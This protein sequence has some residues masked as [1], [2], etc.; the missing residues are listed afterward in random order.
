MQID[1]GKKMKRTL[2]FAALFLYHVP[3]LAQTS[4][5]GPYPDWI[6]HLKMGANGW[7]RASSEALDQATAAHS[8]CLE[9]E[10]AVKESEEAR[11]RI[12]KRSAELAVDVLEQGVKAAVAN[13]VKRGVNDRLGFEAFPTTSVS[14]VVQEA[15]KAAPGE[16]IVAGVGPEPED[17]VLKLADS[18][19]QQGY[20][21]ANS[22]SRVVGEP[23][24]RSAIRAGDRANALL[25]DSLYSFSSPTPTWA[26]T[27]VTNNLM[28][29]SNRSETFDA[30]IGQL[31][32]QAADDARA[33]EQR[34]AEAARIRE[35]RAAQEI[36]DGN[37]EHEAYMRRTAESKEAER[38]RSSVRVADI[39]DHDEDREDEEFLENYR[40][41]KLGLPSLAQQA[42]V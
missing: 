29:S 34:R 6:D 31:E 28:N 23:T 33:I 15:A 17:P 12:E 14:D 7:T 27:P 36:R 41:R 3:A 13:A 4:S 35:A 9:R 40:R 24:T 21:E 2:L 19:V 38:T 8:V 18:I 25:Q 20:S 10:R 16:L 37:A 26:T 11:A 22:L 30:T 1:G 32:R 5:C 39:D 42:G